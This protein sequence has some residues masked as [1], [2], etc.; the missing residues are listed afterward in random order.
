M[1][2]RK[3]YPCVFALHAL[4]PLS[5][6]ILL[7]DQP[8]ALCD[9]A[10]PAKE[11]VDESSPFSIA[12]L[13]TRHQT[14]HYAI[15]G[16]TDIDQ[17]QL[18]EMGWMLEVMHRQYVMT[19]GEPAGPP[20]PRPVKRVN[21]PAQ[22]NPKS[23]SRRTPPAKEKPKAKNDDALALPPDGER[24]RVVVLKDGIQYNTYC[25]KQINS[26]IRAENAGGYF[27]SKLGAL[28]LIYAS[29][30]NEREVAVCRQGFDQFIAKKMPIAPPW[31]RAGLGEY[32]ETGQIGSTNVTYTKIQTFAWANLLRAVNA[33]LAIPLHDLINA[34]QKEFDDTSPAPGMSSQVT[35]TK[36]RLYRMESYSF[37]H[38]LLSDK[39]GSRRLKEFL[40]ELA[41]AGG[42]TGSTIT[43][44][45]FDGKTCERI[46][47][48]WTEHVRK[49]AKRK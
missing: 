30:A 21:K 37:V 23:N 19:F 47:K 16:T 4:L 7:V 18:E 10:P 34:T 49:M 14:E 44:K 25:G 3:T 9:D 12:N 43:E 17:E 38:F 29:N 2:T 11:S 39:G 27:S 32:F 40:Q 22:R 42:G 28:I 31:V 20:P 5:S 45:Y 26:T 24:F 1:I 6:L 35:I 8:V 36:Q 13:K 15:A 41:E 33:R 46:T 48:A